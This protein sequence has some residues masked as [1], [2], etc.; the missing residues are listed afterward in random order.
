MRNTGKMP[1]LLSVNPALASRG[2]AAQFAPMKLALYGGT[3]D[4]I[5][6]GHLIL[7]ADALGVLGVDRVIFIP[8]AVSPHKLTRPTAPAAVRLQMVAAAIEGEPRFEL[9]DS[10][11]SREGPSYTIDTVEHIQARFPGAQLHCL[12]GADNVAQLGTWRRIAEL[13]QLVQFVVFTRGTAGSEAGFPTLPRRI[14]ISASE[15]RA[16]VARG[17]SIRYLVPERVRSIIAAQHL[18]QDPSH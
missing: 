9:D 8:A 16:R 7:A 2:L 1:M 18:Y 10:E 4:P 12:I 13:R 3:F 17:D 14:D 11:L 6:H 5:H 15:I